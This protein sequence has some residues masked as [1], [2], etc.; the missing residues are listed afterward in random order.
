MGCMFDLRSSARL[1]VQD[2]R[3]ALVGQQDQRLERVVRHGRAA[4]QRDDRRLVAAS[5]VL[6]AP[7]ADVEA[8]DVDRSG[9]GLQVRERAAAQC[10]ERHLSMLVDAGHGSSSVSS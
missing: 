6:I 10:L 3:V 1:V 4:V 5:L 8:S 9:G 2:D 7:P